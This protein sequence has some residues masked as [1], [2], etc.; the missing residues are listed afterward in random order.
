MY[1][2]LYKIKIV[3]KSC[4]KLDIL[5]F[6]SFVVSFSVDLFNYNYVSDKK[7]STVKSETIFSKQA[8]EN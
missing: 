5:A 8:I 3:C 6:L 7:T 1:F 4:F 2:Y